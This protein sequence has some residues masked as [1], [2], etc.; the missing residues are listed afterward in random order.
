VN[1]DERPARSSPETDLVGIFS[2]VAEEVGI[3]VVRV[4][5]AELLDR[6]RDIVEAEGGGIVIEETV[7]RDHPE[8]ASISRRTGVSREELFEARLGIVKAE[9]AVA[10]TG[11]VVLAAGAGSPRAFSIVPPVVVV[12]VERGRI[13]A[14]LTEWLRSLDPADLAANLT[15]LSGPSRTA[16]IEMR[17]VTGVH[18]PGTVHVLVLG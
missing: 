11:S 2:R 16:D 14:D 18:G 8:L 3:Q 5:V 15:L 17:L 6:V 7:L 10:E 13:H 9:A 4:P 1:A 12:L